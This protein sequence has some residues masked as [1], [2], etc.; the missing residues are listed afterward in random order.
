[1]NESVISFDDFKKLDI[2]I[3]TI[4]EA[5]RVEGSDK[6]LKLQI[7]LGEEKRQIIAG[8]GKQY[9]PQDLVGRQIPILANLEPK[10]L[11]GLESQGMLLAAD[12]DGKPVLLHPDK[13]V[14][15]GAK[16]K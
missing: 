9:E 8:L 1:M 13:I 10:M 4:I 2:R 5:E 12:D 15:N 6:L 7:D 14:N 16:V 3:G 11:M